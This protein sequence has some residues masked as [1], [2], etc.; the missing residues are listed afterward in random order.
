MINNRW[1]EMW[2]TVL[3]T[4]VTVRQDINNVWNQKKRYPTIKPKSL[5]KQQT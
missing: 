3:D 1:G 4:I 5:K 2:V